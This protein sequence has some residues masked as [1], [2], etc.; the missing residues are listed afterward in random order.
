MPESDTFELGWDVNCGV[1]DGQSEYE[2]KTMSCD[3]YG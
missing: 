3:M 1:V 2:I